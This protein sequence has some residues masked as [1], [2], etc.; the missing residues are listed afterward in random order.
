M[1]NSLQVPT[2]DST[3][4]YINVRLILLRE[5][6]LQKPKDNIVMHI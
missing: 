4:F 2:S 1:E 6:E 3:E 5:A